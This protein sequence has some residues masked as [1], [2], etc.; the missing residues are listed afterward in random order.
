MRRSNCLPDLRETLAL[1][2]PQGPGSTILSRNRL[3]ICSPV[4]TQGET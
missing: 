3:V 2:C 4:P 1:V